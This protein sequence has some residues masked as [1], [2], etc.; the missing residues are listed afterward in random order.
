[1]SCSKL[2]FSIISAILIATSTNSAD[3]KKKT[4]DIFVFYTIIL[5]VLYMI[6]YG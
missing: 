5:N 6:T 3:I 4:T 2:F 1:M